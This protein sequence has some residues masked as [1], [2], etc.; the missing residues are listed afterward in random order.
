MIMAEQVFREALIAAHSTVVAWA[1][2]LDRINVFPV[3]DGDTGANLRASLAPLHDPPARSGD[4]ARQLLAGAIGN[5]GN[6]AAAFLSS[7]VQTEDLAELSTRVQ[8]GCRQSRAAV[9]EPQEGT[10]LTVFDGLADALGCGPPISGEAVEERLARDV[11]N[12]MDVLPALKKAGVVDAG[13]LGMFLFFA[14]FFRRIEGRAPDIPVLDL[15]HGRIRPAPVCVGEPGERYCIDL[16]LSIEDIRPVR[17][18]L[19]TSGESLIMQEDDACLKVHVHT[20]NP[21]L[22]HSRLAEVAAI[23]RWQVEGIDPNGAFLAAVSQ[24]DNDGLGLVSDG[25]GSLPRSVA[26]SMGVLLLDSYIHMDGHSLPESLCDPEKVYRFMRGGGRISTAQA[27]LSERHRC[28][29]A[30]REQW[31]QAIYLCTGSAYTGNFKAAVAWKREYDTG[32]CF[33][34]IDTGAASGRLAMI[35]LLSARHRRQTEDCSRLEE[36]VRHLCETVWELLFPAGLRYLA[37]S[38]RL[39]TT[40]GF[41]GDFLHVLPV[42]SPMADGV[43][44]LGIVRSPAGQIDFALRYISSL[45]NIPS[46]LLLQYSDNREWVEQAVRPRLVDALPKAEILTVPLSLTAGAHLGPGTWGLAGGVEV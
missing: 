10:M 30:I 44:K 39:S 19:A 32:D 33:R 24:G 17:E 8:Q 13:A 45:Q 12:G 28:Y 36:R 14:G 4:L 29:G 7:F 25:A 35:V 9:A 16:R 40:G 42:L 2:L 38:G 15:F 41:L 18:V 23:D 22:L 27:P 20:D 34:V 31:E 43:R 6:I 3:A 26:D 37:R 11:R 5:S 46:H 1:S 21:Q